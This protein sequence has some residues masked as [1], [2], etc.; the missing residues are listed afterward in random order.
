VVEVT[1]S[2]A[3]GEVFLLTGEREREAVGDLDPDLGI[4]KRFEG[5]LATSIALHSKGSSVT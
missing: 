4:L 3:A 2:A 5:E 1:S